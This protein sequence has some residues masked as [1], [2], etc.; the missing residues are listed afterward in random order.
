MTPGLEKATLCTVMAK[1]VGGEAMLDADIGRM[2]TTGA[3]KKWTTNDGEV[4]DLG[5]G[6]HASTGRK[7]K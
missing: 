4:G 2:A 1:E 5:R 7:P 6:T 3:T